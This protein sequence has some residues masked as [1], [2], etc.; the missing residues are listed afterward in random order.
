MKITIQ[1]LIQKL[2]WSERTIELDV[3]ELSNGKVIIVT[4]KNVLHKGEHND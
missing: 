1:Q 4:D 3:V 2:Q